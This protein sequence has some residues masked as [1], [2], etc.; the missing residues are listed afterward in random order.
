MSSDQQ[1]G[2][3]IASLAKR[4]V[5][6]LQRAKD[7]ISRSADAAGADVAAELHQLRDD[8]AAVQHTISAFATAAR[9]GAGEASAGMR[10]AGAEAAREFAA[11]A[12]NRVHSTIAD[13][14]EFARRNPQ[15]VLACALGLGAIL[16]LLMRKR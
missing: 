1:N 4:L 15:C 7:N 9:A 6:E 8:L 14:E 2:E 13:F 11:D 12:S 10:A 3:G 5:E 16:G